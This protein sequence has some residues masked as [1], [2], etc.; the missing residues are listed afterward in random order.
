MHRKWF[1]CTVMALATVFVMTSAA[2]GQATKGQVT[3]G[4]HE[5]E[6]KAGSIY[7]IRIE[8]KD[9]QPRVAMVP[10]FLPFVAQD[11]KMP[12]KFISYYMPTKDEKNT[13]LVVPEIFNIKGKG[14]F[15][16]E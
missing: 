6:M 9:F 3:A 15:E 10:G 13:I 2:S 4:A 12:N 14:P 1:P 11:F 8:G 16:Y 7:A 5:Y